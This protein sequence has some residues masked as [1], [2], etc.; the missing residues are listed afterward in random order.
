MLRT[1]LGI[2]ASIALPL[3]SARADIP[4]TLMD[5]KARTDRSVLLETVVTAQPKD[6]FRLFASEDGVRKFWAPA[7]HIDPRVGGTYTLIFHPATDPDGAADGT[8]GARILRFEPGREIAFEWSVATAS[9][10]ADLRSDE[11]P[12]WVE[13]SFEAVPG[14]TPR[15]R[16]ALAHHGFRSGGSW[17]KAFPYFRDKA[18]PSV[19]EALKKYCDSRE[20][21]DWTR[22]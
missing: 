7:A 17:D 3:A 11:L 19:L 10:A 5:G 1:A 15:T 18:W 16:V 9:L 12:T 20:P 14:P 4:S 2:L 8:K 6:V 13:L 21:R 22:Q